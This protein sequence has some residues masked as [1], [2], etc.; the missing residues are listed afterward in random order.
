MRVRSSSLPGPIDVRAAFRSLRVVPP[1]LLALVLAGCGE[2][3]TP[4]GDVTGRVLGVSTLGTLQ[5]CAYPLGRPDLKVQLTVDDPD[6]DG[7]GTGTYS[8]AALPTSTDAIVIFDGSDRAERVA[9]SLTGGTVNRV[10]DR[11]GAASA[12]D[13]L[14]KMPLAGTVLAAAVPAGGAT[15]W[16]PTFALPATPLENLVPL[17]GGTYAVWPLPPGRFDVG[18]ALPGFVPGTGVVDVVSAT[19][20]PAPVT[21][22][23][24]LTVS[25]P[26]CG[27][28]SASA[29]SACENDLVCEHSDGRCYECTAADDG[30]CSSAGCN[31][32]THRC[33]PPS[34]SASRFCSPCTS[35][36]G[37]S[38]GM[39]C[40]IVTGATVGYCTTSGCDS[41]ADCPAG[42]D[43]KDD[44]TP[45]YCRPPEGCDAWIQTMGAACYTNSRCDDDLEDGWCQGETY[46]TPGYCTASC[47][48]QRDCEVGASTNLLCVSG[49]CVKG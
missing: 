12:V 39:S 10:A 24:D 29:P 20:T 2:L 30:N 33:N 8:F 19:T 25:E 26:G 43:C 41:D 46:E 14:Q 1:A 9:V 38:T 22:P 15:P 47:S 11:F 21:L 32:E 18:A 6:G 13:E 3:A 40:R 31:L 49:H 27:S 16:Q 35:D 7:V 4:V 44:V 36:A 28:V 37:C 45:R 42:F 23:I 5:P 34:S 48:N 17:A